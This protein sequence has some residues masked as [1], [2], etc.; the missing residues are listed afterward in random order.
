VTNNIEECRN[1]LGIMGW[2]Q[3]SRGPATM[4]A[5]ITDAPV[6]MSRLGLLVKDVF[7]SRLGLLVIAEGKHHCHV[8]MSRRL[9]L[10]VK[11]V[12]MSRL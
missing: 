9:G 8:F 10:L 12:F 7:M 2:C 3:G 1:V 5:N 6:F 4:K 11:D